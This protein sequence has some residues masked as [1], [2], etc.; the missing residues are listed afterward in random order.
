MSVSLGM[1]DGFHVSQFR[2]EGWV[3]CQFR[4]EGWVP[5]Q[6]R[7]EVYTAIV[8]C[9]LA[10]LQRS[11]ACTIYSRSCDGRVCYS[12]RLLKCFCIPR[13]H[14]LLFMIMYV[15]TVVIYA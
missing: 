7:H 12:I 3:P 1:R 4:H 15:Q 5:C 11:R 9:N 13:V 14:I 10:F 6:F 8:T 2:H